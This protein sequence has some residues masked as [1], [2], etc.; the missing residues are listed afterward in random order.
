[1]T[2]LTERVYDRR[3][4]KRTLDKIEREGITA[5]FVLDKPNG[6][7]IKVRDTTCKGEINAS[8]GAQFSDLYT[9]D[10]IHAIRWWTDI[11]KHIIEY[12]TPKEK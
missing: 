8:I 3:T 9:K 4:R 10:W 12:H 5:T 6:L 2:I 7:Y 11:V 1:M